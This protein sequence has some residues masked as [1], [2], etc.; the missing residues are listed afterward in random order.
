MATVTLKIDGREA[1]VEQG[2]TVLD[3]AR[4]LGISIPTLCHI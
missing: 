4:S 2:K 1:T 3:A